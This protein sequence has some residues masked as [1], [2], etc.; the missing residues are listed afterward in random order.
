MCWARNPQTNGAGDGR[1]EVPGRAEVLEI[2]QS[3]GARDM[4][5]RRYRRY[6][7]AEVPEIWQ[8]VGAGD[9]AEQ[10]CQFNV[11]KIDN[12]LQEKLQ[13]ALHTYQYVVCFVC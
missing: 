3:G 8:S 5:E 9:M 4:V 12:S 7:R 2:W 11:I 13:D 1:A 10:R 6:G